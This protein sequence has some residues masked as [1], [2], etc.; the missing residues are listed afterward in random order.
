MHSFESPMQKILVIEDEEA[1]RTNLLELLEVEDFEPVGAE[2]GRIGI[3]LAQEHLPDLIICDIMMPE[4]DGI[5]VLT[6]LRQLPA[7]RT[8]PFIFLT[9]KVDRAEL[10]QGMELGAD[11]YLTKPFTPEEL[12][13]AIAAR[14][15]KQLVTTQLQQKVSELEHL[16]TLKDEFLSTASHDL[17]APLANMKT[18]IHL[19][20]IATTEE[21]RS[22][23][24][25]VLESECNRETALLNDLLDLQRLEA[26]AYDIALQPLDL[27][28]WVPYTTEPFESRAQDRHLQF[29]IEIDADLPPLISDPNGL[30]RVLT[31]LL[32]NACK[33][34]IAHGAIALK[35]YQECAPNTTTPLIVFSLKNQA[36][37]PANGLPHIFDKFYRV[38]QLE[39]T[40]QNGT[41]L[42]LPLVQ[43]LLKQMGGTIEA[44]S[45]NGWTV[46]T[47]RLLA[48]P[49]DDRL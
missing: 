13:Q 9:A 21:Q 12:L 7:T 14:L 2:N 24:L 33:Y 11:D 47:V 19:L 3:Q 32:N 20:R 36:D 22:R 49:T 26:N 39:V 5:G 28:T 41:G 43:S 38:P 46:F 17:R 30:G 10:R 37:I 34:T 16:S 40:R 35:V 6:T 8:I 27:Q 23:Y 45:G 42:G 48:K 44:D 29:T 15:T 31:E 1:V 18:A 4:L 25:N